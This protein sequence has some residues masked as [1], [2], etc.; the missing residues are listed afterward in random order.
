MT[1]EYYASV[2]VGELTP[3]VETLAGNVTVT[4]YGDG[5]VARIAHASAE[6]ATAYAADTPPDGATIHTGTYQAPHQDTAAGQVTIHYADGGVCTMN[7]NSPEMASSVFDDV[8]A[9]IAEVE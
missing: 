9:V 8:S 3:P 2:E 7:C 1:T 6:A 5:G 4:V